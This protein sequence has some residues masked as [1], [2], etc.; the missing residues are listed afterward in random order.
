MFQ[1]ERLCSTNSY[2][3]QEFARKHGLDHSAFEDFLIEVINT[4]FKYHEIDE[5]DDEEAINYDSVI[6]DVEDAKS[7][8]SSALDDLESLLENLERAK[9]RG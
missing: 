9:S 4:E 1:I 2:D 5:D 3:S 6:S 7:S 8:V